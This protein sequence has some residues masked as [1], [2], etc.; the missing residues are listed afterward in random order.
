MATANDLKIKIPL[1]PSQKALFPAII[2]KI[3]SDTTMLM[4]RL[5]LKN[6]SLSASCF[7]LEDVV[8]ALAKV[9]SEL[10]LHRFKKQAQATLTTLSARTSSLHLKKNYQA[11]MAA[12]G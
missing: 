12:L 7:D 4:S 6:D 10:E 2:E 1:T 9:S 8:Q 11:A 5:S 3:N